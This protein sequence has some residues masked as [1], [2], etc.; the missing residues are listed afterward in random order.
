MGRERKTVEPDEV[1]L[2][3]DGSFDLEVKGEAHYLQALVSS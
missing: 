2:R 1:E 3:G